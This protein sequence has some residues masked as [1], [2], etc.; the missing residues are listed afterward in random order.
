MRLIYLILSALIVVLQ[1][2]LWFGHGG[3]R[4]V[5][6]LQD[7]LAEQQEINDALKQQNVNLAAEVEDLR[8]G[9]DAVEEQARSE[10][11]LIRPGE[12][13]YLV[14]DNQ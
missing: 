14:V 3:L 5:W 4:D 11:G 1:S 13:Y 10:L 8:Y 7:A 12:T 2:S 6:S 9:T